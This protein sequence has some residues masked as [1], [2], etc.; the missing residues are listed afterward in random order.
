MRKLLC[1]IPLCM[2]VMACSLPDAQEM[3]GKPPIKL[4]TENDSTKERLGC[5]IGIEGVLG[6]AVMTYK[7]WRE[8]TE[9][10]TGLAPML[11]ANGTLV[12]GQVKVPGNWRKVAGYAAF[13]AASAYVT[14]WECLY[15]LASGTSITYWCGV[16]EHFIRR[17]DDQPLNADNYDY[18]F[19]NSRCNWDGYAYWIP[20]TDIDVCADPGWCIKHTDP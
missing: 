19:R 9:G 16:K 6:G 7:A 14:P 1:L 10:D 3:Q 15:T 20:S 17:W 12:Y 18:F 13:T 5:L 2:L 8:G 11:D 4:T